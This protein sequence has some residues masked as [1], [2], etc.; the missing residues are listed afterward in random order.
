[1]KGVNVQIAHPND[2]AAP[3]CESRVP[4]L[5]S[6]GR[7]PPNRPIQLL[8]STVSP[9]KRK[10]PL[11]SNHPIFR[12]LPR[13]PL[14]PR[15]LTS[16]RVAAPNIR[17]QSSCY[18]R[19]LLSLAAG[20]LRAA[21]GAWS[22][23]TAINRYT[24]RTKYRASLAKSAT[25]RKSIGTKSHPAGG[26]SAGQEKSNLLAAATRPVSVLVGGGLNVRRTVP[27][28]EGALG[29]QM[30]QEARAVRNRRPEILGDRLAH[31]GKCLAQPEVHTFAA[32]G[33][34]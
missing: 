33:A 12:N 16:Q 29:L 32:R 18:M 23:A 22:L 17:N 24:C 19:R 34:G 30:A 7:L 6:I 9:S 15:R 26:A 14:A 20:L 11:F 5:S 31:V 21:A 2:R 27:R 4:L 3:C 1:M 25:S 10:P 28:S 13:W 8:E